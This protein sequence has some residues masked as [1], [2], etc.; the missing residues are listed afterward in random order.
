M[1]GYEKDGN[2]SEWRNEWMNKYWTKEIESISEYGVD[3]LM[4]VPM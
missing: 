2:V 3:E 4:N 1:N